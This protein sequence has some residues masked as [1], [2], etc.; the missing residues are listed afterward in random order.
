MLILGS[1]GHYRLVSLALVGTHFTRKR[2]ILLA[3]LLHKSSFSPPAEESCQYANDDQPVAAAAGV[4]ATAAGVLGVS[5][6]E[7]T[8]AAGV[9]AA[10]AGV[11]TGSEDELAVT[12]SVVLAAV[13]VADCFL[14][15]AASCVG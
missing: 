15:L 8:V 11:L 6:D 10:A 5:E 3:R 2:E 1:F 9:V 14:G 12:G 13:C 4:V 7:L